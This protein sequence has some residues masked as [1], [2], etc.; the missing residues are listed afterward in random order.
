M[1]WHR[2]MMRRSSEQTGFTLIEVMVGMAVAVIVVA[3]AI[4]I[5]V[6]GLKAIAQLNHQSARGK[7]VGKLLGVELGFAGGDVLLR[8]P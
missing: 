2:V 8:E 3:A 1:G 7:M 5:V 6:T 4:V